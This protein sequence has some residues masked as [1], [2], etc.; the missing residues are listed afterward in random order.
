M[1]SVILSL[2]GGAVGLLLALIATRAIVRMISQTPTPL[3]VDLSPDARVLALTLLLSLA[4]GIAFGMSQTLPVSN[5]RSRRMSDVTVWGGQSRLR[6]RRCD[7]LVAVQVGRACRRLIVSGLCL[8][9]LQAAEAV[10]SADS[11]GATLCWDRYDPDYKAYT[12]ERGTALYSDSA[13]RDDD[14]R[15]AGRDGVQGLRA[16]RAFD[17]GQRLLR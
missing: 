8:R 4:T 1:E 16:A 13:E 14:L 11:A 9:S 12:A 17:P 6:L 3:A 10:E 15:R 5:V 2:C 7:R